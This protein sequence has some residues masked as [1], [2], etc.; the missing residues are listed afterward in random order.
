VVEDE[1]A[2]REMCLRVLGA[3]GLA[4]DVAADGNTARDMLA[5]ER[6]DL[7]LIDIRTPGI[8]GQELYRH[9]M[10]KYPE[11]VSVLIFTTGDVINRDTQNF[12]SLT[13]RP[14]LPKPFTVE[15]LK[16]IVSETLGERGDD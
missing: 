3:Q 16:N 8:S 4:V 1:P 9:I 2:I 7:C 15:E 10:E 12:L 11:L 13:G 6:Y 5:G 14:F